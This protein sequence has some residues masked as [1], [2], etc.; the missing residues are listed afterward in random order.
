MTKATWGDVISIWPGLSGKQNLFKF[1]DRTIKEK[2]GINLDRISLNPASQDYLG[3]QHPAI[4]R[5]Y[6]ESRNINVPEAFLAL[7]FDLQTLYVTQ[8]TRDNYKERFLPRDTAINPFEM[9]SVLR[10]QDLKTLH[11]NLINIYRFPEG[12]NRIK[13]AI[14]ESKYWP[15]AHD[16]TNN[17]VYLF[18]L[19]SN[20]NL[21]GMI[22]LTTYNWIKNMGY[23]KEK[24]NLFAGSDGIFSLIIF[25]NGLNYDPNYDN[26]KFGWW[27]S[28]NVYPKK[29]PPEQN[30]YPGEYL[31][32]PEA[33][34]NKIKNYRQLK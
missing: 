27:F 16:I 32:S 10:N 17:N 5:L 2:E 30:S 31:G 33:I 26:N 22:D 23:S 11:S 25:H 19:K 21:Y 9:L 6:V 3:R 24:F 14:L 8:T 15:Y 28:T 1:F 20:R 18:T 12:I 4:Q 7:P 29:L 34:K 13:T